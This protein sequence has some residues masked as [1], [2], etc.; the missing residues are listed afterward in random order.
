MLAHPA[1]LGRCPTMAL[2]LSGDK[3]DTER[4]ATIKASHIL[5]ESSRNITRTLFMKF[6]TRTHSRL[7]TFT[8][9]PLF[10]SL[11]GCWLE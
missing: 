9:S 2:C 10:D 3:M 4:G 8:L 6:H 1:R 7:S 5:Q 11:F